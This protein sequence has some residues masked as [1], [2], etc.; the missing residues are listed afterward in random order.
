MKPFPKSFIVFKPKREIVESLEKLYMYIIYFLRE[1]ERERACV[2]EQR[3]GKGR[4]RERILSSPHALLR[5]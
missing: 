3:Q 4:G 2:S 1:R 5:A